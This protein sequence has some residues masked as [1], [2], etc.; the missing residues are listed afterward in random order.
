MGLD[1]LGLSGHALR[2][3]PLG[4][5]E[6][7]LAEV[8]AAE[9]DVELGSVSEGGSRVLEPPNR[10]PRLFRGRG[11]P[12]REDQ[13]VEVVGLPLKNE[14]GLFARLLALASSQI[15]GS[16]LEPDVEVVRLHLLGLQEEAVRLRKLAELVV[17][18]A[19]LSDSTDVRLLVPQ[20]AAVL[21]DRLAVLLLLGIRVAALQMPSFL[22]LGGARAPTRHEQREDHDGRRRDER[23]SCHD[24]PSTP[25]RSQTAQEVLT[26]LM[27]C[28]TVALRRRLSSH[29][30]AEVRGRPLV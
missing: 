30:A 29:G 17:D 8:E 18:E 25:I 3:R 19:E 22:G 27:Y 11:R 1:R 28:I 13:R 16:Q 24:H 20:S 14:S 21:E 2:E 26:A 9:R 5:C 4:G 15:H 10:G 12:G 6:V 23:E 7:L